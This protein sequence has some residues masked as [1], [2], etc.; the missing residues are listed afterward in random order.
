MDTFERDR[1]YMDQK[2]PDPAFPA[3]TGMD[4]ETLRAGLKKLFEQDRELPHPL[5]A[6]RKSKPDQFAGLLLYL[7]LTVRRN[8]R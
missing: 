3:E 5:A 7:G 6:K 8:F 2:F 1:S 4:A